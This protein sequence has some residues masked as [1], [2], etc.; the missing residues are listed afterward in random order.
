M[1]AEDMAEEF[2]VI[3]V[4]T[5]ALD[6]ARVLAEQHFDSDKVLGRLLSRLGVK[7]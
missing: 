6:A 1:H 3:T 5:N 4:D 2:P 7:A